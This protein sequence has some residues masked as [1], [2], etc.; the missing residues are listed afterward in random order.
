MATGDKREK[1]IDLPGAGGVEIQTETSSPQLLKGSIG[2][3][4][5]SP[6]TL[7]L[8]EKQK[9]EGGVLLVV[10]NFGHLKE[11]SNFHKA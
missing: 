11:C 2:F 1:E 6:R 3:E 10:S 8:T 5:N 7:F 9:E 4:M